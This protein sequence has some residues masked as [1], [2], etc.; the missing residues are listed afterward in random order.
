[1][2]QARLGLGDLS[3]DDL[4]AFFFGLRGYAEGLLRL[5]DFFWVVSRCCRCLGGRL[6][7][8]RWLRAFCWGAFRGSGSLLRLGLGHLG[9]H[10]HLVELLNV[11]AIDE[12]DSVGV[13]DSGM[14]GLALNFEI[15]RN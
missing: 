13:D 2:I 7:S 12:V 5:L 3:C 14:I 11:L 8:G 1:M 15:V 6:S 4:F 10:G 9:W